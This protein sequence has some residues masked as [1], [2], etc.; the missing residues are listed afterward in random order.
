MN[1]PYVP[2]AGPYSPPPYS[3]SSRHS[4]DEA[5]VYENVSPRSPAPQVAEG[6][7]NGHRRVYTQSEV[8][9]DRQRRDAIAQ[10]SPV[11]RSHRLRVIR[12]TPHLQLMAGPLLRYDTVDTYGVWH[13]FCLVVSK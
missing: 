2:D 8:S 3:P 13:G 6:Y 10:L 12:M 4:H 9:V 5:V 1:G 11:E 7:A